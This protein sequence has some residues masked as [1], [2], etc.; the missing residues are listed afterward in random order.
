MGRL[1]EYSSMHIRNLLITIAITKT[2]VMSIAPSYKHL[3]FACFASILTILHFRMTVVLTIGMIPYT[4]KIS[5][6]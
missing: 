1:I 4:G 2:T 3:S 5:A 6:L